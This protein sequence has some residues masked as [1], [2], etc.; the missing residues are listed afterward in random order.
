MDDRRNDGRGAGMASER[1]GVEANQWQNGSHHRSPINVIEAVEV[2]SPNRERPAARGAAAS[3]GLAAAARR[4]AV[5]R[6]RQGL[7]TERTST[8]SPPAA[9]AGASRADHPSPRS[10]R[11]A[12]GKTRL[13][14]GATSP[15]RGRTRVWMPA[16]TPIK[17]GCFI[18]LSRGRLEA[19]SACKA[20][21][22]RGE[23][24]NRLTANRSQTIQRA[25][26][27]FQ[28]DRPATQEPSVRRRLDSIGSECG[29]YCRKNLHSRCM[30][31]LM[32]SEKA[33]A[34]CLYW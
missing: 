13:A 33:G 7:R 16:T 31:A 2:E 17:Q 27:C 3:A 32:R 29:L 18:P 20:A 23:R 28:P 10:P 19:N 22:E 8:A 11:K 9:L 14:L 1:T 5:D 34:S 30:P 26:D 4:E 25:G 12:A 21:A 15:R 24:L 6:R